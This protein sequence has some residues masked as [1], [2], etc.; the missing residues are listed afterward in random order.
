[1]INNNGKLF[2]TDTDSIIAGFKENKINQKLGEIK[3]SNVYSDAVFISSKFYYLKEEN[4]K[5]KGINVK[6]YDFNTI[7]KDFYENKLYIKFNSQLNI[8]KKDY[9]IFLEYIS[10]EI[11]LKAYDKRIFTENKKKTIPILIE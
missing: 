2:Y 5:I 3:W 7:K 1:V 4:L 11:Y 6:D 8:K 10:K 9:S